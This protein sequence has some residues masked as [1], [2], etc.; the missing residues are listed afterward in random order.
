[1]EKKAQEEAK[2][3]RVVEKEEKKTRMLEYL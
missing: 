2:K 1:V 3:Q